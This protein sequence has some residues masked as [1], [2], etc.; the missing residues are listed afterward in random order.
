[1]SYKD[2]VKRKEAWCTSETTCRDDVECLSTT[3]SLARGRPGLLR[4]SCK[5][6]V[7]DSFAQV[8]NA[9]LN[10]TTPSQ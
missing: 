4:G 10:V 7:L 2:V 6:S 8:H 5:S 1:M 3:A 9:D